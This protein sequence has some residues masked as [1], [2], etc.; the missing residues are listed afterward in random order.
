M[1]YA[2]RKARSN[3]LTPQLR[4]LLPG[5]AASEELVT[6]STC[7]ELGYGEYRGPI[8]QYGTCR[9]ETGYARNAGRGGG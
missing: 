2:S 8:M 1:I 4:G 5:S 6:P 3:L 7:H 9:A